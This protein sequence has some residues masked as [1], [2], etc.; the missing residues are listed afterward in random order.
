M[1]LINLNLV[2]MF[3][4][5]SCDYLH[6]S[7]LMNIV[8]IYEFIYCYIYIVLFMLFYL[9]CFILRFESND[10]TCSCASTCH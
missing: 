8:Y 4:R 3:D 9:Y 10:L 7:V 5:L 2:L 6:V 1:L